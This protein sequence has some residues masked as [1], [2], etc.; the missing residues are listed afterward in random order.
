MN[1]YRE[2]LIELY[3]DYT[4]EQLEEIFEARVQFWSGIIQNFDLFYT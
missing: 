3:P 2:K 4:E 1:K